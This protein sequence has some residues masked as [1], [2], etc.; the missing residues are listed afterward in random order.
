MKTRILLVEDETLIRVI[1]AETLADEGY[2]VAAAAD[3]DAAIALLDGP[4]GFAAVVTDIHMPG[5][6]DGVAVS[7][8]ARKKHPDIPVIYVT[9]RPDALRELGRMTARDT[10]LRKPVLPSQVIRTLQHHAVQPSA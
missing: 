5:T 7:R 10:L 9:G 1:L 6:R 8:H 3:G 2:D 4:D